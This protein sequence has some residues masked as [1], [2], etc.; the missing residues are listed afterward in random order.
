MVSRLR[1]GG[2][3]PRQ[4]APQLEQSAQYC[5]A[6]RQHALVLG[7]QPIDAARITISTH[8]GARLTAM[9]SQRCEMTIRRTERIESAVDDLPGEEG[10]P[11]PCAT[12]RLAVLRWQILP[13]SAA[14]PA[15]VGLLGG[16]WATIPAR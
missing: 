3:E 1:S 5:L 16:Q 2:D 11:L 12:I 4:H 9:R 14:M 7:R 8:A 6:A 15:S 10:S 13:P